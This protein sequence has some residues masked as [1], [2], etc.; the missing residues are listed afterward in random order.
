MTNRLFKHRWETHEDVMTESNAD[1]VASV[2]EFIFDSMYASLI[3]RLGLYCSH[4]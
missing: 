4:M 2:D 1:E 3:G